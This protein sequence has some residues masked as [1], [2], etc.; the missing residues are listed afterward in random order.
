MS[1]AVENK[2][3]PVHHRAFYV[4]AFDSY[5]INLKYKS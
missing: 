2:K 3:S 4:R 1:F 5:L